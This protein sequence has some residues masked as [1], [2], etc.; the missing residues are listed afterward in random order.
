M[1]SSYHW[2]SQVK[3]RLGYVRQVLRGGY[4]VLSTAISHIYIILRWV[5]MYK[6]LFV[7]RSKLRFSLKVFVFLKYVLQ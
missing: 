1:S 2:E 5:C 4:W 6:L 7:L 3:I